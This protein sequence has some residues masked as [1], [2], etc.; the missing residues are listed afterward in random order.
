[1]GDQKERLGVIEYIIGKLK[2]ENTN[3]ESLK[4]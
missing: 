4:F 2:I 1:M 3:L